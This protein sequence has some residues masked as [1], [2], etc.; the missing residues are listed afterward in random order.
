MTKR[1]GSTQHYE[2]FIENIF[3][4]NEI[5]Y[6]AIDETKRSLYKD[7][8]IKNFDFIV[9]SFKGKYL[10]DVKGK[11]FP[12]GKSGFWENCIRIDDI[13]GLMMWST[14]FFGFNPLLVYPYLLKENIYKKEFNDVFNYI[15]NTYGVVAIELSTYYSNAKSRSKKWD[16]LSISRRK[17]SKLGKP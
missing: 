3:R 1:R 8:P 17:F 10:I 15:G 6:I 4:D 2:N 11:H 7:R 9:S 14:H 5:L 12:Y 16:A 13:E